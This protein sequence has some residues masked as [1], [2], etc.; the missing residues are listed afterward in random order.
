LIGYGNPLRRDDGFGFLLASKLQDELDDPA[1]QVIAAHQ[2]TPELAEPLSRADYAIFADASIE[3]RDEPAELREISADESASAQFSHH[4]TPQSLLAF[5]H[6][7]YG[8]LPDKSWL[9]SVCARDLGYGEE[10]SAPVAGALRAAAARVSAHCSSLAH[11][12]SSLE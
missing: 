3:A 11:S 1:V 5:T 2:L 12:N 4:V 9:L 10:L 6:T 8:K 7:L